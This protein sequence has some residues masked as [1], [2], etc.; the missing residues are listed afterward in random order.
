MT[1]TIRGGV[2]TAGALTGE[3]LGTSTT[4]G[5]APVQASGTIVYWT[6]STGTALK[7]FSVGDDSV[8]TYLTP[9]QVTESPTTCIGCHTATPDGNYV[10]V[11]ILA[12][13][14]GGASGWPNALALIAPDAGAIGSPPSYLGAGGA[15]ALA[16]YNQGIATFSRGH[17]STGDRREVLAYDNNG[18]ATADL[19]WVDIEATSPASA[20]GTIARLGDPNSAGAPAWSHDGKTIA[21][22]STN[23]VCAGRL[24]A[25]CDGQA[26]NQVPDPGSVASIYTVP[27]QNGSG[28]AAAVV[29]GSHATGMQE[30]YPIFSPDD[31]WLAFARIPEGINLYDQPAAEVYVVPSSGGTATRLAAND[32]PSCTGA[33]SPGVTNSWP[34]WGPVAQS[35]NGSTYYWL[36]FSSTRDA[37]QNPQLYVTG[38]VVT[39]TKVETHGAIYLWNQPSTENNHT[40]AWDTFNVPPPPP[41]TG[42]K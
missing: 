35:A 2:L 9:S 28:G 37:A 27:Y 29:P 41:G 23:R 32:P 33:V 42:P 26:Y 3:S 20:S 11:G 21:Y 10:G 34:K 19:Q 15:A 1:V 4:M 6:T 24:G 30:Y 38:V 16:R 18:S 36:V 17:W 8:Q 25:G 13:P 12:A 39:G 14:D 22:T 40:P 31:A 5:I 7:G